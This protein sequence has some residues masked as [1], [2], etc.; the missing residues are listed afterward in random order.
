MSISEDLIDRLSTE[1]GRKLTNRAREGRRRA[2]ERITSF[3]V[4]VTHDG[5]TT[6]EE[7]FDR[8]PTLE[9]IAARVGSGA[10]VLGMKRR[11][12]SLTSRFRAALAA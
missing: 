8:P 11:R 7:V 1:A 2:L 12:K 5:V 3:V 10:F 6:W 9:Q 4:I